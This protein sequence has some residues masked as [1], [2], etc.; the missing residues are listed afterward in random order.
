MG[1]DNEELVRQVATEGLRPEIQRDVSV[2]KP[3]TMTELAAAAAIA[4][5]NAQ[6][7]VAH[8]QCPANA[9][10]T[11]LVDM[12]RM[13]AA[14]QSTVTGRPT[15]TTAAVRDSTDDTAVQLA[16][17]RRMMSAIQATIAERPARAAAT[18]VGQQPPVHPPPT[19]PA[20]SMQQVSAEATSGRQR[21][22]NQNR[23]GRGRGRPWRSGPPPQQPAAN[24]IGATSQPASAPPSMSNLDAAVCRNCGWQHAPGTCSAATV[25]YTHL[26]LPTILR[27]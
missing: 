2:Q 17:L 21:D 26:T 8:T 23:R 27:V 25:S 4:E 6:L 3:A 1:L 9:G 10:A 20:T 14:I 16:E 22:S 24:G 11:Q 12:Q 5:R 19:T 18:A 7:T 15:P 13:M